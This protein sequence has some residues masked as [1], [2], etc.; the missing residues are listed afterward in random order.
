MRP[1]K[2]GM[3]TMTTITA[4]LA[5]AMVAE[6]WKKRTTTKRKKKLLAPTVE[7]ANTRAKT[8]PPKNTM[9]SL[10]VRQQANLEV[11]PVAQK[12]N[13]AAVS[14]RRKLEEPRRVRPRKALLRLPKASRP[15]R[16]PL[17]KK[18]RPKRPLQRKLRARK[19]AGVRNLLLRKVEAR[20]RAAAANRK[21]TIVKLR[22][23]SVASSLTRVW[24][25]EH[26]CIGSVVERF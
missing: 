3:R 21:V 9:I 22:R 4:T 24:Q 13:Q 7:Q 5:A 23:D 14:A 12:R 10:L 1:S 6:A 16:K 18:L 20:R 2:H 11:A 19:R 17:P 15:P 8:N 26:A 25:I